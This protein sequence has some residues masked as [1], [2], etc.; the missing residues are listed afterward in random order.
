M[1]N[2]VE[3][4][5]FRRVTL[6]GLAAD[7]V[8]RHDAGAL[9]DGLIVADQHPPF[10][11]GDGLRRVKR[12]TGEVPERADVPAAILRRK[13]VGGILDDAQAVAAGDSEDG[14]HVAGMPGDVH[15]NHRSGARRDG[16]L[17]CLRRHVQ[18]VVLAVDEHRAGLEVLHHLGRRREGHG[19]HDH[20]I[21]FIDTDGVEREMQR[22]RRRV[23]GHGLGH[24]DVLR[25]LRFE[26]FDL[27]TSGEPPRPE[28]LDHRSDL[29]LTD[30]RKREGQER[31]APGD[32]LRHSRDHRSRADAHGTVY[33][34]VAKPALQAA[35]GHAGC[36]L[37]LPITMPRS[38]VLLFTLLLANAAQAAVFV[39]PP[40][41]DLID[42]ADAIVI[43]TV[44]QAT[45]QFALDGDIVT[46]VEIEV[47]HVLKGTIARKRTMQLTELGGEVGRRVMAVSESAGYWIGNRALI[48]LELD[49]EGNWRTYGTSLGKFDFVKD[50]AGRELVVRWAT[51]DDISG[52]WTQDGHPHEEVLR[53]AAKF[54]AHIARRSRPDL[55]RPLPGPGTSTETADYFVTDVP[56]EAVNL[57]ARFEV[58]VTA[59]YPPSAYT[60]G[61]FRWD[62][63]DK[64]SSVTFFASGS[65]PG[66]DHI[67]AAQRALAAW[68]NEPG[69]NINYVYGG[70]NNAGF[71]EDG[72]NSIVYNS[73]TGVPSGALAY[74]KWYADNTHTYKGEQ[75][76]SISEGDVVMKQNPGITQKTFDEAITHELGHTLGFRHSD[77]GSPSSTQ[78]VMKAVLSG[79][80]GAS[81]GPWDIEAAQ[82]VYT[83]APVTGGL[84]SVSPTI[85]A[86]AISTTSV[87]VSWAGVTGAT[88]YTLER[89]TTLTNFTPIRSNLGTTSFT[90]TGLTPNTTYLYRVRATNA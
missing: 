42:S 69:S 89:G 53:D 68:T 34:F 45:G 82:H 31:F 56:R 1:E 60:Q 81:L 9:D 29:L 48:F 47:E 59:H 14:L 6:P 15:G 64:G 24:S 85:T 3:P 66:Y 77:Q 61:T 86:T 18:R 79:A 43:G 19:R 21:A 12:E 2:L 84:P 63:F 49:D 78:A 51:R 70:T 73:P 8:Q 52:F 75:F 57:P 38:L 5:P 74:A 62:R 22:R 50:R 10:S 13:R 67:G 88:G 55:R 17:E 27:R 33:Q 90:D 28:G 30:V 65:Q 4:G 58:G 54:R 41:D 72:V 23:A 39:V 37:G 46:V 35:S 76:Y 83:A 36:S 44:R 26:G 71:V 20:F 25:E 7:P 11:G 16:P 87:T 40:D 80:F 32:L